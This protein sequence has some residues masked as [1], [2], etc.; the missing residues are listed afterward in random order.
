MKFT[1]LV[2][3]TNISWPS[4]RKSRLRQRRALYMPHHSKISSI[5]SNRISQKYPQHQAL[6][7][8]WQQLR[9]RQRRG[10]RASSRRLLPAAS[11]T[12][13]TTTKAI[14]TFKPLSDRECFYSCLCWCWCTTTK[15]IITFKPL[16]ESVDIH[17]GVDV[18]ALLLKAIINFKPLTESVDVYN[19]VDMLNLMPMLIPMKILMLLLMFK[20]SLL[21]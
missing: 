15:A 1:Q 20:F 4:E 13:C 10:R 8:S 6:M 18:A 5:I 11:P 9:L 17:V 19:E 21:M 7:G 16:T 3:K 14:I 12:A 2:D